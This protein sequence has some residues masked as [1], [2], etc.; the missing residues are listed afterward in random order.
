MEGFRSREKQSGPHG[1]NLSIGKKEPMDNEP[2]QYLAGNFGPVE[3][4]TAYDLPVEGA[5]PAELEGR[6]LRIGPNPSSVADPERQRNASSHWVNVRSQAS[7]EVGRAS[8]PP[9]ER[10]SP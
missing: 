7:S 4:T 5:I 9:M 1:V 2:N 10:I 3:E 6:F 8:R